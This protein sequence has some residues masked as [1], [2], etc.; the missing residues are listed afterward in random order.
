M[1]K[2]SKVTASQITSKFGRA[3]LTVRWITFAANVLLMILGV[4]LLGVG[5]A[6]LASDTVASLLSIPGLDTLAIALVA[7]GLLVVIIAIFGTSG[8]LLHNRILLVLFIVLLSILVVCQ[9]GVGVAATVDA[10]QLP[11]MLDIAWSNTDAIQLA[12]I[13]EDLSCCGFYNSTDRQVEPCPVVSNV[14]VTR[15]CYNPLMHNIGD[16]M[17]ELAISAIVISVMEVFGI[18]LTI[19]LVARISKIYKQYRHHKLEEQ[20][21]NEEL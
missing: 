12:S 5:I 11:T 15:G 8:L 21:Q 9:L 14:T 18:I 17:D 4:A 6:V 20:Q 10:G 13:Q 19:V 3:F 16:A 1:P 2:S 7:I